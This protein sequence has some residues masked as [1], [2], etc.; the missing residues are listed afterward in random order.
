MKKFPAI[1]LSVFLMTTAAACDGEDFCVCDA[2][3]DGG[4]V[5][6]TLVDDSSDEEICCPTLFFINDKLL[7][8]CNN[9]SGDCVC[10]WP[11]ADKPAFCTANEEHSNGTA[12]NSIRIEVDGYLSWENEFTLPF[13]NC[14]IP[15]KV[16]ARLTPEPDSH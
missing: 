8:S 2:G 13:C 1:L 4:L 11:Q 5:W 3:L 6:L 15:E 7:D 10:T 14:G 9:P 16:T 12:T